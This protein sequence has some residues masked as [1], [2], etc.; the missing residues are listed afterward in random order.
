MATIEE[1]S[2]KVNISIGAIL[3]WTTTIISVTFTLTTIYWNFV[4]LSDRVDKRY[5]RQE[6]FNNNVQNKIFQIEE[7]Y[8]K[9]EIDILK[10]E[11]EKASKTEHILKQELEKLRDEKINTK[12]QEGF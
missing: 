7:E 2:K 3:L 6:V 11:L 12:K 1:F 9:S 4:T 5:N 8:K 10:F